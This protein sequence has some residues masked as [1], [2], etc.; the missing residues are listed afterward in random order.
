MSTSSSLAY[1]GS[2]SAS[3]MAAIQA[4]WLAASG[5]AER[6]ANLP[7]SAPRMSRAMSAMTLPVSVKSTWATKTSSPSA[8]GIGESQ[9]TTLMPLS[10][11]ALAAGTIWSPELLEIMIALTPWVVAL[12][13]ISIWP[14]TLFSGVGPRN[15]SSRR[16][17]Q[18]LLP[19]R[20]R[21]GGPGRR[22]G[23]RGTS[24]GAPC[25]APCR[26][27]PSPAPSAPCGSNASIA[28]AARRQKLFLHVSLPFHLL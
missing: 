23:C 25:S 20:A 9:V 13:T 18:L 12:V 5:D 10:C 27:S 7:P 6:M 15:W 14:A 4:F 8:D 22:A 3:F 11:A 2:F 17:L 19:L 16:V 24:A 21:P 1:F 28:S 26:A